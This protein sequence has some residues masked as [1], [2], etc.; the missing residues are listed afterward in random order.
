MFN[1]PSDTLLEKD[2]FSCPR[3]YQL[4]IVSWLG[5]GLYLSKPVETHFQWPFM[6]SPRSA[7]S[8]STIVYMSD[9]TMVSKTEIKA[10]LIIN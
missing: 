4:L 5:V 1:I 2:D 8:A 10:L 7:L 3:R 6:S 9:V